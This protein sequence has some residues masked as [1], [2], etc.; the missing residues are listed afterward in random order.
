MKKSLM[1]TALL[2]I[3]LLVCLQVSAQEEFQ[4]DFGIVPPEIPSGS[5]MTAGELDK[6]FAQV[7]Q[8]DQ[9]PAFRLRRIYEWVMQK[10]QFDPEDSFTVEKATDEETISLCLGEMIKNG[11]SGDAGFALLT[12]YLLG[13]LGHPSVIISGELKLPDGSSRAHQWNFVFYNNKWYHFDPL[14]E[15]LNDS[16]N[17]F[18]NVD[19]DLLGSTMKWEE[20]L[21]PT[22]APRPVHSPYC[23][24]NNW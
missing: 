5:G 22:S 12:H 15:M 13:R 24:C 8:S 14:G 1:I 23:E 17:G 10:Y 9:P 18:M 4:S 19:K 7:D 3:F 21:Q 16:L 6:I 20:E 2:F 11:S